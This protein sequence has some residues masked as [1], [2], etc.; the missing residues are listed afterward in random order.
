MDVKAFRSSG[1]LLQTGVRGTPAAP[2]AQKCDAKKSVDENDNKD[3]R[4]S[5]SSSS[6]SIPDDVRNIYKELFASQGSRRLKHLQFLT[7]ALTSIATAANTAP[8]LI[9]TI[10]QGSGSDG[11]R[12]GLSC[13]MHHATVRMQIQWWN[14][15]DTPTTNVGRLGWLQPV[16]VVFFIDKMPPLL[17]SWAENTSFPPTGDGG[18][19]DTL[20]VTNPTYYNTIA[21]YSINTHGTRYHILHDEVIHP[22]KGSPVTTFNGNSVAVS[23]QCNY[24]WFLKLNCM[25]TWFDT[26]GGNVLENAVY[27]Q[28]MTDASASS[29]AGYTQLPK[30]QCMVDIAYSEKESQ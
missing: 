10:Q 24:E 1:P 5:T 4:L 15:A 11:F 19:V 9:N 16:R 12:L 6:S 29:A 28:V 8:T 26:T 21:P 2:I 17:S 30:F 13:R 14:T 18:L 23:A 3:D 20:N 25:T 22:K 27:Y 7:Q